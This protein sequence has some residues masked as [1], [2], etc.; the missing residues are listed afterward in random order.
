[1][2]TQRQRIQNGNPPLEL[3]GPC[4][5]NEGILKFCSRPFES[6]EH[7]TEELIRRLRRAEYAKL[8]CEIFKPAIDTRYDDKAIV[9]H[10]LNSIRMI[11]VDSASISN[12]SLED[13]FLRIPITAMVPCATGELMCAQSQK[14]KIFDIATGK[15]LQTFH[16]PDNVMT[17][18][19]I[20]A[21]QDIVSITKD[22]RIEIWNKRY[23]MPRQT[24]LSEHSI[25]SSLALPSGDFAIHNRNGSIKIYAK[26]NLHPLFLL[27]LTELKREKT[28]LNSEQLNIFVLNDLFHVCLRELPIQQTLSAIR[29]I[30]NTTLS[31]ELFTRA[32]L[33]VLLEKGADELALAL[34]I[35][36]LLV[37]IIDRGLFAL[38][39]T[40]LNDK[41]LGFLKQLPVEDLRTILNSRLERNVVETHFTVDEVKQLVD[42]AAPS[43]K[44]NVFFKNV[45][46]TQDDDGE[47]EAKRLK[48]V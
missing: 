48:K 22:G 43:V 11:D 38:L 7:Q 2:E 14:I 3:I 21:H 41:A 39:L 10:D 26:L 27:L 30:S 13:D 34:T 29:E 46:S 37:T 44:R 16:S 25:V 4:R 31:N 5:I 24:I 33:A 45:I 12:L 42:I 6:N 28:V 8:T 23:A 18:L 1:M 17:Q 32:H 9:S 40:Q 47:P 19:Q 35:P 36:T 20:T 15:L